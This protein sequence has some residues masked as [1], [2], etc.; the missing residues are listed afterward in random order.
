VPPALLLRV[1]RAAL[2]DHLQLQHVEWDALPSASSPPRQLPACGTSR[3]GGHQQRLD[4][5]HLLRSVTSHI[6]CHSPQRSVR[7][8]RSRSTWE[9]EWQCGRSRTLRRLG[10]DGLSLPA[11][12]IFP[13]C[14]PSCS[15]TA[16]L[17]PCPL[18]RVRPGKPQVRG[19]PQREGCSAP[20]VHA[21]ALP[22]HLQ[23]QSATPNKRSACFSHSCSHMLPARRFSCWHRHT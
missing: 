13:T 19:G 10:S 12:S 20:S 16:S 3:R 2:D 22:E 4:L 15:P 14:R 8:C 7:V 5:I 6:V 1:P 11:P 18:T 17:R 21:A 23:C 9:A